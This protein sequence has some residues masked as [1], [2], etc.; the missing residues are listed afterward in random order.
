MTVISKKVYID[1]LVENDN[2]TV[3]N[4]IIHII[5]TF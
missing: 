1:K 3:E 5:K 2:D 4:A